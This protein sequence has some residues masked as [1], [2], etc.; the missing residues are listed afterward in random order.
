MVADKLSP[1]RCGD[2]SIGG[3]SFSPVLQP[4]DAAERFLQ[5]KPLERF[6]LAPR[7]SLSPG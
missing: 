2:Q 3:L 7:V 5:V 1:A 4:G 6:P